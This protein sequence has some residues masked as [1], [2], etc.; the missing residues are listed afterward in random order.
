M[1]TDDPRPLLRAPRDAEE[2][3]FGR[4]TMI[5]GAVVG[6][7][8]RSDSGV[9]EITD[10]Q[11]RNKKELLDLVSDRV[12]LQEEWAYSEPVDNRVRYRANAMGK[13]QFKHADGPWIS[14]ARDVDSIRLD[15]VEVVADLLKQARAL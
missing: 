12:K 13:V 8:I 5:E 11:L 9:P 7:W 1:P 10:N 14:F 2:E 3:A 4:A 6:Y 15:A